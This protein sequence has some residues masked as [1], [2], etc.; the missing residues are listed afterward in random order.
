MSNTLPP[1]ERKVPVSLSLK[2]NQISEV[3]LLASEFGADRSSFMSAVIAYVLENK[4]NNKL[5]EEITKR[6]K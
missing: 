3:E 4:S 6:L 1:E 2:F 5:K